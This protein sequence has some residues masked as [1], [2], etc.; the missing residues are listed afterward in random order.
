MNTYSNGSNLKKYK[1]LKYLGKGSYGAAILVELRS[2]P[3]Q[4]FVIKEI[5]IGHLK[6]VEQAAAKKEAEV[7]H[8]MQHSNIT[9][10]VESFVENSKLFI[11]M[12][13]ADGGDLATAIAKRK[14]ANTLL[15]ENELM[16]IFV[17]ICLALKHVHDHNILH[18]DL[19]SQNIFLNSKGI[20][21][22]GDFGIAK[23]L[24][25]TEEQART[26]IGTPYYLS[27]EICE[28]LPYGRQSDV[29]SLG[30]LL[31]ELLT[32]ELPFQAQS[33]PALVHKICSADPPFQKVDKTYSRSISDL[34]RGLLQKDPSKRPTLR[35]VVSTD[36][37][38][39]HIC[40]L[41]SHTLKV[42]TGGVAAEKMELDEAISDK[43][44]SNKD[45]Q[46]N[47][48]DAEEADRN[49]ERARKQQQEAEK[50]NISQRQLQRQAEREK[51]R[52][53]KG[54]M[55]RN[56]K[57]K[58]DSAF[59][60][61]ILLI[62]GGPTVSGPTDETHDQDLYRQQEDRIKELERL[63]YEQQLQ[64]E[65]QQRLL[66]QKKEQ[67]EEL[68]SQRHAPSQESAAPPPP[69]S[70]PVR[71]SL[72][73]LQQMGV[74]DVKNHSASKTEYIT[75]DEKE[76]DIN[77][78]E[79]KIHVEMDQQ[80]IIR[81]QF[82]HN[83]AAA[84]AVKARVEAEERGNAVVGPEPVYNMEPS[85]YNPNK[86]NDA[87]TR[88]AMLRAE[89]DRSKEAELM[90]RQKQLQR[91]YADN[92]EERR[93]LALRAKEG[94]GSFAF[95]I[96]IEKKLSTNGNGAKKFKSVANSNS[97]NHTELQQ[98]QP[99]EKERI[100]E[101][102]QI[103]PKNIVSSSHIGNDRARLD[104]E[105]VEGNEHAVLLKLRARRQREQEARENARKVF[106]RLQ[107]QR[108][109][110]TEY[111]NS[112]NSKQVLTSN[113][114]TG[115]SSAIIKK[116]IGGNDDEDERDLEHNI[117]SWLTRQHNDFLRGK[118]KCK[119]NDVA[120]KNEDAP[121][122]DDDVTEMQTMLANALLID[123]VDNSEY[124]L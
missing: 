98:Q 28:S 113:V 18:R 97:S 14:R 118:G 76:Q 79:E 87:E 117:N 32:F 6:D 71:K 67:E 52:K 83:R 13:Y 75:Y 73:Q 56:S 85:R 4:K 53:F 39:A 111:T 12:E 66:Q 121:E 2:N 80:D 19:K 64:Q 46:Y 45:S 99:I 61:D 96:S 100:D 82:F 54:D 49:I 102:S 106:R 10:Y 60:K 41:L 63:V 86:D 16:R 62:N 94:A 72:L 105:V 91:A 84:A 47:E 17:Q 115:R 11:V 116:Q 114:Y 21:K 108:R 123:E 8:Q 38:K 35:Q 25:T 124:H 30:V 42:G 103:L 77:E 1:R 37:L 20:I 55:I 112:T 7:L 48:I 74:I 90:E 51:L 15:P 88:I 69:Y 78:N 57:N 44:A 81:Q 101:I 92:R 95:D 40:K 24:D 89:R 110:A 43:D 27:P 68:Q 50:T 9:M 29:W 5:V 104:D 34:V 122:D 107:E 59:D 65:R 109:K 31:F 119:Q 70:S 33:L 120:L 93:R 58:Q 23:V 3:Q 22:L 26:Q 36:F